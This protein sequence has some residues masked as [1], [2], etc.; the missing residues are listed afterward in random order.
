MVTLAALTIA[1]AA[2]SAAT[3]PLVSIIPIALLGIVFL[4]VLCWYPHWDGAGRGLLP[5]RVVVD[6]T[7]DERVH[8]GW[9][10]GEPVRGNRP[11]RNQ[12]PLAH[13]ATE[14][15][16]RDHAR[17]RP[18]RLDLEEGTGGEPLDAARRPN[19][20]GDFRCNHRRSSGAAIIFAPPT[21]KSLSIL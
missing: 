15:I 7:D 19:L 21:R 4:L 6:G 3:Y 13:T 20:A 2:A 18:V 8:R 5:A 9:R 11:L 1:S 16:E 12:H 10:A 14:D 17:P